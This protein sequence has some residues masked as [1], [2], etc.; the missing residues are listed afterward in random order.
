MYDLADLDA[1][2]FVIASGQSGNPLS[3]HYDDFAERWRDVRYVRI[4]G[5]R[6]ALAAD[7]VGVL[8]LVPIAT[9]SREGKQ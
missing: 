5:S 2:R 6:E 1:S 9:E 3:P 8:K 7:G 4:A